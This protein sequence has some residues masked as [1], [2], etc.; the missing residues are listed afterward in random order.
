MEVP[1]S[2]DPAT[3]VQF[4]SYEFLSPEK[5]M[6][7]VQ[8][9]WSAYRGWRRTPFERRSELLRALGKAMKSKKKPLAELMSREM[10]KPLDQSIAEIEKCVWG[11]EYYATHAPKFLAPRNVKAGA[12]KSYV[13]FQPLGPVLAIMPWN[14]PF[15]QV[16]RFAAPALMAGD[17]A[18]LKHAPNVLGCALAIEDLFRE[19]GYPEDVFQTLII[20]VKVT[21]KVIASPHVQAVTLTGSTR[22]GKAVGAR[23]GG[24]M[25]KC[26]FELGGNDPYIILEDADIEAAAETCVASRLINTGQ[27]CIA[28]KRFLVVD[29]VREAF[30]EACLE[31]M[32]T[33]TMGNALEG[34]FDLG[35]LAREDLRDNLHRQVRESVAAGARCLLGGD[36]PKGAG[37]FYP[38]TL[39]TDV[40]PGMAAFDEET[41][42]P[43]AAI[44]PVNDEREAILLANT[45]EF[46]LGAAVF[47]RDL[48]RG[49]RIAEFELEAGSCFVNDF[50]KSDPRLPF[51]GIKLSGFGR[52]LS[53]F[54]VRE[55]VN[56]KTVYIK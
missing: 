51:G 50:V 1:V 40:R 5:A 28:A 14:F 42:G 38:A 24:L 32:K 22:A 19:A 44:I 41:F 3:G 8:R 54:G 53:E 7:R 33:K 29:E 6:D 2:V 43:A 34:E 17:T 27:S 21:S 48:E 30:Q 45:T 13:S 46:G 4:E 26:V 23:A 56:V 36:V 31:I 47:T 15:W 11:C 18:L 37:Y 39:L 10:G 35:P 49:E 52:E 12:K 25:K 55:F 20:D 9:S 16:F